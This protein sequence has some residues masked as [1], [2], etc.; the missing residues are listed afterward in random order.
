MKT[1]H[2]FPA[3][4]LA[5]AMFLATPGFGSPQAK[6]YQFTGPVVELTDSTIVLQKGEEKWQFAHD[7]GTKVTGELKLGAKVTIQYRCVATEIEVK[8]DKAG[9]AA[10]PNRAEKPRKPSDK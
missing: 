8:S 10:S 4:A 9:K 5:G 6:T 1:F 3:L 2:S 7:A